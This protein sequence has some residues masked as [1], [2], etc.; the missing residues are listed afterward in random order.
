VIVGPWQ[1]A[2]PVVMPAWLIADFAN[3]APFGTG[4]AAM[5]EFAPTWQL[6]QA[7]LVGT[8]FAGSVLIVKFA[9]GIAKPAATVGPWHCAQLAVVLGAYRWMF[10]S[11]G[12]VA[13]L[14]V[15]WQFAQV[16][17]AA[18]GMWFAGFTEPSK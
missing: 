18:V 9:A 15:V 4:V 6:S 17:E 1:V 14:L 2:Q 3:S 10:A 5:L 11:V 8:W 7:A 12:M 16:A 13:K